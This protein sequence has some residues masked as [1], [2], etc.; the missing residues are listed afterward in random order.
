MPTIVA[1]LSNDI[2]E[3]KQAVLQDVGANLKGRGI[4]ARDEMGDNKVLAPFNRMV[5]ATIDSG[6]ALWS[7]A[8]EVFEAV[9]DIVD[10]F[11]KNFET[12]V[13]KGSIFFNAG[14]CYLMNGDFDKALYYWTLAESENQL[15]R[16][17]GAG[18]IFFE[19]SFK[20]NLGVSIRQMIEGEVER[21]SRI[22]HIL[23]GRPFRFEDYEE[24][25]GGIPIHE[26]KFIIVNCTKRIH[27]DTLQTN[28]TTG[29]L[30]YRLLADFCISFEI[31]LKNFL[32]SRGSTVGGTL[33]QIIRTGIP[34]LLQQ[35]I[36]N[37]P[38][39]SASDYNAIFPSL[40]EIIDRE[41][42]RNVVIG[43]VLSLI[44]I[45][46]NQVVHDIQ[47]DNRLW[48]DIEMCQRLMRIV[49]IA[50]CCDFYL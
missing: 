39:R 26:L 43:K 9:E 3:V 35:H 41:T 46:R 25:L 48:G 13:H 7:N 32:R 45:T 10:R 36:D 5:Q 34:E 1:K 12:Q 15:T 19:D 37:R 28:R 4:A 23:T 44:T 11:E 20:K 6:H 30:Y 24:M 16:A 21:E 33:G 22:Y 14:L 40:I 8:I 38:C 2:L 49:I 42:D 17:N 31:R 18:N 27:Y 50:M 29:L 47:K